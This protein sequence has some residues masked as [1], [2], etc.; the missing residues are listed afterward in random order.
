MKY[1]F[2]NYKMNWKLT[3]NIITIYYGSKKL[4]YKLNLYNIKNNERI[5]YNNIKLY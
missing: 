2:Y 4:N 5:V 1:Y 3:Y